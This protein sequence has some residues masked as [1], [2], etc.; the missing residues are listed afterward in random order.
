[1]LALGLDIGT[2]N[3]KAA[4]VELDP[5][6]A[7][8]VRTRAR[9]SV[10]TPR[11][12]AALLSDVTRVVRAVTGDAAPACV[13]VAAM[14][15]TGVPLDAD[16]RPLGDL[17]RWDPR[18]AGPQADRLAATLGRDSLVR[19]TGVRPSGKVPL[20]TW[21]YLREHEPERWA[22]MHRW[23]GVADLVVHALTGRL[24]TDHTLAG[25][26][27]AYR[28]RLDGATTPTEFDADLLAAV[29]MTPDQLPRV[30][31]PRG[32]AGTVAPDA[33][34]GGLLPPGTR[35]AVAGH[36]HPVGAWAAGVRAPDDVADSIG[37]AEAVLRV[38]HAAPDAL[39]VAGAGMSL[40]RTVDGTYPALLAGSSSAGAVVH[41]WAEQ[42]ADQEDLADLLERAARLPPARP[43][44]L[45]LPYLTGR[46]TPAPDPEARLRV[47]GDPADADAVERARGLLDGLSLHARWMLTEQAHLAGADPAARQ[48]VVL[49]SAA[50]PGSPWLRS[51]AAAGPARLRTVTEPEPVAAGAA[52][53]AAWRAG[54][55]GPSVLPAEPAPVAPD[56]AY[57]DLYARFVRAATEPGS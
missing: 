51:K 38:V 26:T 4:V 40:V 57:D 18:R 19:A 33:P 20:A 5:A 8:P 3:V 46:Q 41:W 42:H 27:M 54:L 36:D 35:V 28:P 6:A 12:G 17:V 32:I 52:L 43:G 1:M 14:A 55:S 49:G 11:S 48:V 31:D 47:L 2:S 53:L 37:T 30:A 23:A 15:E 25:R 21:A 34:L 9:A 16:G 56:R 39:T 45:V 24:V 22:A 44:L 10:P 13:G 7:E 29:G 50:A